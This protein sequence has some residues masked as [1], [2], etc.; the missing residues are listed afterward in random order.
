MWS[1]AAADAVYPSFS[2]AVADASRLAVGARDKTETVSRPGAPSLA[3]DPDA[4]LAHVS[5]RT[6]RA[7]VSQSPVRSRRGAFCRFFFCP[8]RDSIAGLP[9]RTH[10]FSSADLEKTDRAP[11]FSCD[12]FLFFLFVFFLWSV[13]NYRRC[14]RSWSKI[15][16]RNRIVFHRVTRGI[17]GPTKMWPRVRNRYRV[18]SAACG[19]VPSISQ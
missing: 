3:H 15:N 13:A 2:P 9:A 14:P 18:G 16:P 6:S 12:L 17:S 8:L 7:Q 5:E 11:F 1:A 10:R 19:V 4:G